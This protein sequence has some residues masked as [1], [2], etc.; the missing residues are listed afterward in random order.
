MMSARFH[1]S[2]HLLMKSLCK[3]IVRDGPTLILD[4]DV[5]PDVGDQN[6]SDT[7]LWACIF[8]NTEYKHMHV[9]L[10]QMWLSN[11]EI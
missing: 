5:D 9:F 10:P 11:T 6:Y 4:A 2:S 3:V 8:L 1:L 7:A